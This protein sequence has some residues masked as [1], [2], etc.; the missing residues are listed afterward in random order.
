M[1]LSAQAS[2][3]ANPSFRSRVFAAAVKSALQIVGEPNGGVGQPTAAESA[4]RQQLGLAVLRAAWLAEPWASAFASAV[5]ANA[6]ILATYAASGEA[7]I[8]DAD[9]EFAV[10]A[11]WNDI[12]GI[13]TA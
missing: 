8:S 7:S 3:A 12:A 5:A 1:T 11:A 6:T 4:R 2:L 13:T 10:N 9:I